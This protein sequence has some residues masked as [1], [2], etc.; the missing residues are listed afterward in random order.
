MAEP[1]EPGLSDLWE[2]EISIRAL[3]HETASLTRWASQ[4][5]TGVPSTGAMALNIKALEIMT[6]WWASK[7]AEPQSVPI[8]PIRLEAWVIQKTSKGSLLIIMG[9]II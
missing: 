8:D 6:E 1:V 3:A 9:V 4:R 2:K 5:V 7:N